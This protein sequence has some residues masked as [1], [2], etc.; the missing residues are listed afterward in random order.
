MNETDQP[1][2][3]P[4]GRFGPG[5]PG[6]PLGARNRKPQRLANAILEHFQENQAAVLNRL[7][8]SFFP[9]Y[10]RLVGRLLPKQVDFASPK[11]GDLSDR[12]AE[13]VLM[14]VRGALERVESGAGSLAD[15]E[16]ALCGETVALGLAPR[17]GKPWRE[18]SEDEEQAEAR[19]ISGWRKDRDHLRHLQAQGDAR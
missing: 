6:R 18:L 19:F 2:R 7:N 1:A 8:R 9:E 10:V 11:I 14:Q 3:Y 5:N 4:N 15:I 12:E 16:A 17:S 13:E